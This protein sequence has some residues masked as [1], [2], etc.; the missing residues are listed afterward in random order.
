MSDPEN[1][2]EVGYGRPPKKSQFKKGQSGNPK[3]RPRATKNV[4]TMLEEI[5][6]KK[7]PISDNGVRREVSMLEAILRQVANGAAKG[8][9][10]H[11]DRVLKLLPVLQDSLAEDK[12][13]SAAAI[14]P[15][16]DMAVLEAMAEIFGTDPE[17]LFASSQE[18]E[19]DE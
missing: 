6:F 7:I 16:A 2:Y 14:D 19:S 13:N 10:R 17:A 12:E 5:F 18:G 9:I 15:A 4:G 11:V 3:G 1:D 8:E